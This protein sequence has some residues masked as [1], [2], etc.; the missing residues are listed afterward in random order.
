MGLPL[1][2]YSSEEPKTAIE[3][4]IRPGDPVGEGR[5]RTGTAMPNLSFVGI[6]RA[7][8][9][10]WGCWVQLDRWTGWPADGAVRHQPA[11]I[12]TG[13]GCRCREHF[14]SDGELVGNIML[15][16]ALEDHWQGSSAAGDRSV[17]GA[18]RLNALVRRQ[19][20]LV[21][22]ECPP[23][24]WDAFPDVVPRPPPLSEAMP[25]R[26]RREGAFHIGGPDGSL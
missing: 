12:A 22:V 5:A 26:L 20:G 17:A 24:I 25:R 1:S 15:K 23:N 10:P 8:A 16:I 13:W 19:A 6:G 9:L 4:Q 18:L 14:G 21:G 2:N 7:A 11:G 3:P